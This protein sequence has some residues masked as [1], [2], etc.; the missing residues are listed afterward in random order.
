[1]YGDGDYEN[2]YIDSYHQIPKLKNRIT[3]N[4]INNE[5]FVL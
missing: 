4:S 2:M 5:C 3:Y 1:M